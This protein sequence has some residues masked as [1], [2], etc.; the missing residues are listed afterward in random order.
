MKIARN[1]LGGL[2][3]LIGIG[4]FLQ[5]TGIM[6]GSLMSGQ[7]LWTVIGLVVV[8]LGA[9]LLVITNLPQRPASK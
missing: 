1:I 8:V 3:V 4:W 7:T 9:G 2:M 5:G 6:A